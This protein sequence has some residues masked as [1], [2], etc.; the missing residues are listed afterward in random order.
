M[1]ELRLNG[2]DL[3]VLWKPPYAVDVTGA[4]KPGRNELESKSPTCGLTA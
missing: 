2:K 3:G 4:L 1:A